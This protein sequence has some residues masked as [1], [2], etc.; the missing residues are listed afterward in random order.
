MI[1]GC[2]IYFNLLFLGTNAT[3]SSFS[4]DQLGIGFFMRKRPVF[5]LATVATVAGI[6]TVFPYVVAASTALFLYRRRRYST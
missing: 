6:W 2:T 1:M 4:G 3:F 5:A